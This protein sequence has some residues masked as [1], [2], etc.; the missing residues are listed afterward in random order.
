MLAMVMCLLTKQ[1]LHVAVVEI[2]KTIP[3]V[4]KKQMESVVLR[5]SEQVARAVTNSMSMPAIVVN[6]QV[7]SMGKVLKPA[8]VIKLLGKLG[9]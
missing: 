7:V 8:E 4:E 9:Y 3:V 5:S 2:R 1:K 6:E